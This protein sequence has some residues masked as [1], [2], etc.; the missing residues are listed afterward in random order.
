V[1]QRHAP[2]RERPHGD[3]PVFDLSSADIFLNENDKTKRD[4][5]AEIDMRPNSQR[6]RFSCIIG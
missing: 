1:G 4:N 2:A 3:A 5:V 6:Q